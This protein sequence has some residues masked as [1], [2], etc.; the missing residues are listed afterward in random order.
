MPPK[1]T[2]NETAAT[3]AVANNVFLIAFSSVSS[4]SASCGLLLVQKVVLLLG[5][6]LLDH[7]LFRQR[8]WNNRVPNRSQSYGFRRREFGLIN[9]N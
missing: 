6:V 7:V 8:G 3:A 1:P 5:H 9:S 4:L 2:A